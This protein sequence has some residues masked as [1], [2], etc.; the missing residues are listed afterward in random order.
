MGRESR[1]HNERARGRDGR[2][3]IE[4]EGVISREGERE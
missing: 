4:R 3:G 1:K 2:E